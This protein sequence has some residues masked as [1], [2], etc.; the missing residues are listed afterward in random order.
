MTGPLYEPV[1]PDDLYARLGQM[2]AEMPDLRGAGEVTVETNRWLG[3]ALSLVELIADSGDRLSMKIA[4][5]N[6]N[7]V[8]RQTNAQTIEA[9]VLSALARAELRASPELQGRFIAAN[10]PHQAFVAVG[11]VLRTAK[12]AVLII[13]AYADATA[14]SD[15]AVQAEEGVAIHLL[16]DATKC[17]PDLNPAIERWRSQYADLR[18][19]MVALAA[20]KALHDRLIIVDGHEVWSVGQ[21]LNGI[22]KSSPSAIMKVPAEAAGEKN[23]AY[24]QIW[25]GA[26]QI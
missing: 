1:H 18:P 16:T 12:T 5:Q 13:D 11:N 9:I 25:I 3:R 17:K 22:G 2:V 20:P 21:S 4:M 23:A 8:L 6:L 10:S 7:G 24:D 14:L 15:F 19:L 26:E